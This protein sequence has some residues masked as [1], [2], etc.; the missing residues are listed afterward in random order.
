[1]A[2]KADYYVTGIWKTSDGTKISH[3]HLHTVDKEGKFYLG[4][5]T[6]ESETIELINSGKK[7]Q[8]L[9]WNYTNP[10]WMIGADI[11]VSGTETNAYLRTDPDAQVSDNLLHMINMN[12]MK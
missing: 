11:H 1:M 5:K 3:V 6:T 9:R 4:K 2:N 10:G 8:T 12:P 7:I